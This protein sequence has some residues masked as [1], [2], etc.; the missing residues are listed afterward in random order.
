M[1]HSPIFI[2]GIVWDD[3]ELVFCDC[4]K[5]VL[6]MYL[7]LSDNRYS[8]VDSFSVLFLRRKKK[9]FSGIYINYNINK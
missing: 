3:I 7:F 2:Y 4:L 5:D 1:T 6:K 8:G 9:G